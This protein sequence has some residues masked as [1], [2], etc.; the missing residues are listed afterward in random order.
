MLAYFT[1]A[2]RGAADRLL[3]E[4]VGILQARGMR[5]CGSVQ[6]NPERPGSDRCDMDLRLLTGAETVRISQ[7]LGRASSGCRLD[8]GA[9]ERAVGLVAAALE[10]APDLLVVNKF[11]KQEVE[12]RGFRPLIGEALVRGIPVLTSVTGANRDAFVAFCGG[13]AEQ[14][15]PDAPAI[16]AWAERQAAPSRRQGRG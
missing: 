6:V 13:L 10:G 9:L 14:L 15:A 12:G 8:P 4:V 7:N 16:C 11:G 5:I 1:G 3:V 2:T